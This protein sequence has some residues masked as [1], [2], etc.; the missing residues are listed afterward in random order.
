MISYLRGKVKYI[1]PISKKDNFFILDV[2]G[3]GFQVLSTATLV[4]KLK[5]DDQ[6]EVFTYLAVRED[7]QELF[8]FSTWLEV[9]FFKLLIG[10]SG[11][12]PKKA[13]AILEQASISDIQ[14]AVI[15]DKPE[16]LVN[17]SGLTKNLSEKIVVGLQN[18]I[19]D[20]AVKDIKGGADIMDDS[21][22]VETLMA[23]GFSGQQAKV[24]V[25]KLSNKIK[26]KDLRIKEALK[27]LG[28]NK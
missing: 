17:V 25:S 15:A 8:G 28:N 11:I 24:G 9:E 23:L 5:V 19:K 16:M 6:T 13:L 26:D 14:K 1:K 18:K 2:N 12:G 27:I 7:A 10:I 3:Q 22:I 21:E 4:H 20:L